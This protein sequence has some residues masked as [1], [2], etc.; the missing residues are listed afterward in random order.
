MAEKIVNAMIIIAIFFFDFV[1]CVVLHELGHLCMGKLTGYSMVS[2]RVGSFKLYKK[3]GKFALSHESIPGT[4]G[5]CIM[6]PPE[7]DEPEKL[8]S[9]PYHLGGGLFNLLTA[10]FAV[11]FCFLIENKYGMLF[12]L[13][14]FMISLYF[15]LLNLFPTKI[16]TPNDGYN[17]KLALKNPA[18]RRAMYHMLQISGSVDLSPGEMPES[19][20]EISE[21]GEYSGTMKLMRAYRHLDS[22][23]WE[24][25]EDLFREVTSDTEKTAKYYRLEARKELLFCMLLREAPADD[26]QAIF[27]DELKKYLN[28]RNNQSAGNL[29][30]LCAYDHIVAKDEE[31]AKA[32]YDKATRL[33]KH[34]TPGDSKMENKLLE[35][36]MAL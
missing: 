3:N 21:D 27:D 4:L 34:A 10:A 22:G 12:F 9:V 18:D 36:V 5:Q 33:L 26:I 11:P 7:T 16:I 29:R 17:I 15:A 8:S 25:A 23:E 6:L 31:K 14:L 1:L 20:F 28:D 13:I 19:Y 24:K 32:E 30:V 2:F 35:K